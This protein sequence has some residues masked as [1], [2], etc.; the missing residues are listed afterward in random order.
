MPNL[1]LYY[2]NSIGL[3]S[4]TGDPTTGLDPTAVQH[5][6]SF[7]PLPLA[8]Y[9]GDGF[10]GPGPGGARIAL[11]TEGLVL[12]SDGS[13]WISDEYGPYLYHFS[14][15]GRMLAALAPP[16]AIVPRRNG[17]RSFSAAS[18]P[19][20]D[21]NATVVPE[22]PESGRSNNQGFE[23]LAM[24]HDGKRL[25]ALLQSAAVQEGGADDATRRHARLVEWDVTMMPA[26]YVGERV[27]PLPLYQSKEGSNKVA[28]QSEIYA[29]DNG[30]FFVLARDSGAGRGADDTQ[31][32]YRQIDVFDIEGATNVKGDKADAPDGQI[33]DEDGKLNEGVEPAEY[34]PFLDFNVNAQLGKFGL[35]NGGAQDAGLLNEKWEG[36]VVAPVEPG[37]AGR[38]KRR[39]VFVFAVS[40]NDFITQD[41][42]MDG[43]GLKYKDESG[44][45]VDTQ[46][47][48]FRVEIGG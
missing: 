12:A 47:L 29:L 24:G 25:F 22:D 23:G 3:T 11:D 45:D 44:F 31:S 9:T 20:Y 26:K 15:T 18:P 5:L 46:A 36:L 42:S 2:L 39:D 34:C 14:K 16:A 32:L 28:A 19:R 7:P 37:Q 21:P 17:T 8:R 10:G 33:A 6:P 38:G 4:P 48:V 43:G 13:F 35:H 41:G 27:V 40:D 30:Q 1:Q